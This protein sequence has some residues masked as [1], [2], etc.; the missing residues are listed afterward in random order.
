MSY[1]VKFKI[2]D[3]ITKVEVLENNSPYKTYFTLG[4]EYK[5]LSGQQCHRTIGF[6]YVMNDKGNYVILHEDHFTLSK[7]Y[8]R[9]KTIEDI[10]L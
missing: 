3:I 6:Q 7:K 2:G 1:L 9:N 10:L 5:V 8:Y 4:M